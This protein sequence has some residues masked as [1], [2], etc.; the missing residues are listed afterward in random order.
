M[1]SL[2]VKAISRK[3][4]LDYQSE[5]QS[6]LHDSPFIIDPAKVILVTGANGFIGSRVVRT[7]LA[8]GFK[9]VRCLTRPTSSPGNLENI[10]KDLGSSSLDIIKGNLL[11][12]ETCR[13]AT[14]GVSVIYH[15]AAGVEKSYPGCF[16]NSVVTTRNLLE[17]AV[18]EPSLVRFVNV[19]SIALYSNERIRRGGLL[20]ESSDLDTRLA[21]R[22]EPYVYGKAKQ[23]EILLEYAKKYRLPY[24]IVRPGVVFGPGKAK[25]TDRV[26]SDTFGVFLHKG[27]SNMIPLTYVDNCAEAIVLAGLREGVDGQVFNIVD[28]D[29]PTSRQ[30]LRRYKRDVRRF[31]SIP[32]PYTIWRAFCTLWERYSSW[33]GGQLP[34]AFNRRSCSIY[35]KG[36]TYSNRK[37]KDLLGWA[38]RTSM[39]DSLRLFFDYMRDAEVKKR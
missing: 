8:C 31:L 2:K 5:R 25:I 22:Y 19:S 6:V 24:V 32:V 12:R 38:P 35:W 29:L 23:D 36:N 7:L 37:A 27:L 13:I 14:E 3:I 20:D 26:G 9:Q 1:V 16:L 15:L 11:S 17:A 4:S 21:E 30:F 18:S 10:A 28:D 39:S 34:P 33:S